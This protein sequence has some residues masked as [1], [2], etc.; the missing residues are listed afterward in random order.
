MNFTTL[1]DHLNLPND[2]PLPN[3]TWTIIDHSLRTNGEFLLL[4]FIKS[5]LK[6][7]KNILFISFN[8][9]YL[10]YSTLIKKMGLNPS[11]DNLTFLSL[12]TETKEK[13]NYDILLNLIQQKIVFEKQINIIFDDITP[14]IYLGLTFSEVLKLV[15]WCKNLTFKNNGFFIIL[16]HGDLEFQSN[17]II[18]NLS[19]SLCH[20]SNF[21]IKLTPLATGFSS[22]IHGQLSIHQGPLQLQSQ[23]HGQGLIYHYKLTDNQFQLFV[24]GNSHTVL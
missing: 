23:R 19:L 4:N 1:N 8:N 14:L 21:I 17:T 7:K 22:E 12:L 2:L 5:G 18:K 20:L 9:I 15:N 11:D 3:T 13:L 6:L 16:K 10:H 24:K